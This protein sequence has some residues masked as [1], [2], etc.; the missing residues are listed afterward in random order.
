LSHMAYEHSAQRYRQWYA[1]L[2]RLYPRSYRE[3]LGESMEQTFNDICR[4]RID[5]GKGLFGFALWTFADTIVAII[6]E[7]IRFM[8][9]KARKYWIIIMLVIAAITIVPTAFLFRGTA[10]LWVF[11]AWLVLYG[12]VE[13]YMK[14]T[15]KDK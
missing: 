10:Y 2:L 15:K 6:K 11:T 4:E 13:A 14:I 8:T 7:E 12:I 1:K 3:H 5:A 9:P